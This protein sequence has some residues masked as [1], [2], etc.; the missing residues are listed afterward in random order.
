MMND[1]FNTASVILTCL[2]PVHIGNGEIYNKAQYI[3]SEDKCRIFILNDLKWLNFLKDRN[4]LSRYKQNILDNQF[5]LTSWA[6]M[7]NI[8]NNEVEKLCSFTIA[9]GVDK[10]NPL[11]DIAKFVQHTNGRVYIPGSSIKGAIRTAILNHC[12]NR[13]NTDRTKDKIMDQARNSRFYKKELGRIG[14]ALESEILSDRDL[15]PQAPPKDT[16]VRSIMKGIR[17]GDA[18]VLGNYETQL[19]LKYDASYSS[20]LHGLTQHSL[21]IWRECLPVGTQV[22]FDITVDKVFLKSIGIQSVEDILEI[23]F[24]ETQKI[25]NRENDFL[26]AKA[27]R[28][29]SEKDCNL[30]LGGGV[31]FNSKTIISTVIKDDTVSARLTNDILNESFRNRNKRIKTNQRLAPATLK[32]VQ[33]A[34]NQFVEMGLCKLEVEEC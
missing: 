23:T 16:M 4:L 31:G 1:F 14:D 5:N 22:Q 6:G 15:Y 30:L 19:F 32:V 9:M 11:N 28:N 2:T 26:G 34:S 27:Y 21:P 17:V 29:A 24:N 13:K 25:L 3:L 8:K 20:R 12:L 10:D 7:Q 18:E 33:T